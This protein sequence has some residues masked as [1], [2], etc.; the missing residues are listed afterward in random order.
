MLPEFRNIL[1]CT[2]LSENSAFA[3]SYALSLAKQSGAT[4]HVLHIA[5]KLSED[6]IITLETYLRDFKS[7]EKFVSERISRTKKA[8][9]DRF[10]NVWKKLDK[11]E[12]SVRDQIASIEVCEAYPTEEILKRAKALNCDLIVMGAH[13]KGPLRAFLGSVSKAVLSMSTIPVL[14]VP[15][16]DK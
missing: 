9:Q 6:A 2:D 11:D 15:L 1:Y 7:R 13:Q 12:L 3:C 4:V 5:E 14:V 8:L 16:P 10:D